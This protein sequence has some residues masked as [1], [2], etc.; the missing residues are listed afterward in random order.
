MTELSQVSI[1]RSLSSGELEAISRTLR[2]IEAPEGTVLL[3]EGDKGDSF[4]IIKE[5]QVEVVKN[6]GTSDEKILNHIGPAGYVGEMSLLAAD[7]RRNASVRTTKQSCAWE[8]TQSDFQNLMQNNP[9]SAYEVLRQLS[10]RLNRSQAAIISD[11]QQKNRDLIAAYEELKA[12]Q[13]QIIEKERLERE[14]QVAHNIQMSLLPP[15]LPELSGFDFGATMEPARQ[16]GGD[17][18]DFI[19]LSN[20]RMGIVIGDV[21]DKGV[22]A[23]IFMARAQALIRAEAK[24]SNEVD[25]VLKSVNQQLIH[26]N[27]QGYFVTVLYGV[28]DSK[29]GI[30]TYA[31]AGHELPIMCSTQ[32]EAELLPLSAGQ[33]LGILY[34]PII[35]KQSVTIPE[36][37]TLVLYTDGVTDQYDDQNIAF[38]EDKLLLSSCGINEITAQEICD[39]LLSTVIEYRQGKP[40]QD[41]VTIVAIKREIK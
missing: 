40:L 23:A 18:Y 5:G 26:N 4:L 13:A 9:H 36:G 22:P 6:L 25:D 19:P 1:F 30:F 27:K 33:P 39:H 34:D 12:A 17:L 20:D 7:G 32:G 2:L 3:K 29:T 14:L 15:I 8:M 28:L 11:L 10:Q 37:E 31:R 21:T 38:G 24:N 41:D 16:V 35:D